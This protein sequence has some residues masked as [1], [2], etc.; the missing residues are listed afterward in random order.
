M[1][2]KKSRQEIMGVYIYK[3]SGGGAKWTREGAKFPPIGG[4]HGQRYATEVGSNHVLTIQ[5]LNVQPF[6][7]IRTGKYK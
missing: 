2:S 4:T 1:A 6:G 3:S 7:S 5:P